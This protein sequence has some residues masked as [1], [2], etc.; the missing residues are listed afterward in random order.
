MRSLGEDPELRQRERRR[1]TVD[2]PGHEIG[3]A[4]RHPAFTLASSASWPKTCA[5]HRLDLPV[6]PWP[7]V[8]GIP[9]DELG[10]EVGAAWS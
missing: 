3:F 8:V 5:A 6:M 2:F 7:A 9:H 10:E 1:V 4:R